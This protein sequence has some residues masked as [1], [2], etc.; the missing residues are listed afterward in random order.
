VAF[1]RQGKRAFPPRVWRGLDLME[2]SGH[3]AR[4]IDELQPH[5]V[6]V[7]QTGIGSGVVDRLKQLETEALAES[8]TDPG[9]LERYRSLHERR[10]LLSAVRSPE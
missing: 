5:A 1:L 4:L 6:F 10:R 8:A 3:C 9:A 2:L 7:D